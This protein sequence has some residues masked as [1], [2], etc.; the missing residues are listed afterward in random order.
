MR[1]EANLCALYRIACDSAGA[2]AGGGVKRGGIAY[3]FYSITDMMKAKPVKH[4]FSLA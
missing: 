1:K 3:A 4:Y 2:I